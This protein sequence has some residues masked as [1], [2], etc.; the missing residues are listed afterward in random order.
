MNKNLLYKK[1]E[2]KCN[3]IKQYKN[4]TKEDINSWRPWIQKNKD[5]A[6]PDIDTKF[7][8]QQIRMK[9]NINY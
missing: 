5:I 6:K 7:H 3:N 2:V 9:Q 4:N 1:E 8:M